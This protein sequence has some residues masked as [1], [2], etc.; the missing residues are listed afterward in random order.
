[1]KYRPDFPNRHVE[2]VEYDDR[3]PAMFATER[4]ALRAVLPTAESIEHIGSTSIP[5][6]PAK[7]TI[8]IL[9]VVPGLED[10]RASVKPLAALGYQLRSKAFEDDDHHLFFRKVKHRQ[11]THHLH[12]VAEPSTAG[13]EYRLLREYLVARPDV[14]AQYGRAKLEFAARHPNDRRAYLD[15]KHAFVE[16]LMSEARRWQAASQR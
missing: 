5:G 8:D 14:A 4:T 9:A 10:A 1:V 3:W 2:I 16:D 15:D 12:V 13:D 6:I 7:P 11:R